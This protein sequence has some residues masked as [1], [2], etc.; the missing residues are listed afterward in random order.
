MIY[1]MYEIKKEAKK[2]SGHWVWS[3]EP[4]ASVDTL[5]DIHEQPSY[6]IWAMTLMCCYVVQGN[7]YSESSN[8]KYIQPVV[9]S[10]R[11]YYGNTHKGYIGTL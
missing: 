6:L 11:I 7:Q 3:P 1:L 10:F 2:A 5:S 9:L 8:I 4:L